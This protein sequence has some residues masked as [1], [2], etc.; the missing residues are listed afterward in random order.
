MPKL[1][2][3]VN[4]I[5]YGGWKSGSV[6]KSID[7]ISGLFSL[8]ISEKWTTEGSPWRLLPGDACEILLDD[9]PLIKGYIDTKQISASGSSLDVSL[10]GRDVTGDLV[11]CSAVVGSFSFNKIGYLKLIRT[12]VAP[13]G[14]TEVVDVNN[15]SKELTNV[16]IKPG[17][18][19]KAVIER[20]ARQLGVLVI[21]DGAGG[22]QITSP[23]VTRA[24]TSLVE[25]TNILSFSAGLDYKGRFSEYTVKGQQPGAGFEGVDPGILAGPQG[26][27][28]DEGVSRYRPKIIIGEAAGN[29]ESLKSRAGWEAST[30]AGR[31][32]TVSVKVQGW[33]QS[34]EA[35]A[36]IWAINQIVGVNIPS[37]ELVG[38]M[39]IRD[40]DYKAGPS[41]QATLSLVSPGIYTP[42][43]KLVPNATGLWGQLIAKGV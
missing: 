31:S 1:E 16:R 27:A 32:S 25:G 9:T 5:R 36:P 35:D 15:A 19:V 14:I 3:Q 21:S 37:I 26:K 43:P 22:I 24:Q 29:S 2:L 17:E 7:S 10:T 13:F 33:R 23:G 18:T 41:E 39:L 4:G 6:K 34:K 11:D 42:Q 40:I 28:T 8:A 30:R 12:L 20:Y 38:D